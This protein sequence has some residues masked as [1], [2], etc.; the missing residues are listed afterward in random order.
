V[1]KF[2]YIKVYPGYLVARI[3]GHPKEITV[4]CPG[5]THPRSLIGSFDI[6]TTAM[7]KVNQETRATALL[8]IQPKVFVHLIPTAEGGYTQP[9]LRAVRQAAIE[10]GFIEPLLCG[11]NYPALSDQEILAV[12][13]ELRA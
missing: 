12:R 9:E 10:A 7:R 8:V 3:V 13:R 5:L 6:L 11:G 4:D 2:A 1:R